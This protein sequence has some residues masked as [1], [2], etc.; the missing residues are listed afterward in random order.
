M[1][2]FISISEALKLVSPFKG[3]KKEVLAFISN[4][5]TAFEV[6]DPDNADVLYKFVL[7]RISGEPR[8]AIT[9]RNLENWEDT[10]TEKRTLD[11]HATQ[12]FGAKQE[13]C[14]SVSEWIQ[15]IQKLSSKFREAAL[16]D[17]EDDERVGIV[18]LGDKL[19][20]IC[21][22]QGL[23]SDRIQTIVRSRNGRTFDEIAETALEEESA[24]FSRN[25]RH[26][27]G[28]GP[29]KLVCH[30]CGKS[31]HI[32]AKC[33]L[34]DKKDVR[35]NK[36]GA[37]VKG[38]AG[39][40][41]GG[42]KRDIKCYNC[43]ETGHLSRECRKPRNPRRFLQANNAGADD[44]PPDKNAPSIGTLNMVRGGHRTSTE[45]VRLR[46]DASN[47]REL[48]LLVDTGADVSLL[49]PTN[50]DKSKLFDPDGR[51]KVKSVDGTII[52]TF[53]TVRTSVIVDFLKIPF[54]FQL[55]SKQV[56]IPCDGILG[57][58]FLEYAGAQICYTRG[59]LTFGAGRSKVSKALLP[60]STG[61]QT[62]KVSRLALPSRAELMVRLP[63]KEG[64]RIRE[65]ITE[66]REIQEGVYLAGAVTTVQAGYAITSIV[67]TNSEGVEIDEPVLE[68]EEIETGK[69]EY[70]LEGEVGGKRLNRT[71]EVL[72]RLRLEHLNKE[73]R[74]QVEKMC[75]A[76]QDI[77]HLPGEILTSTTTVQH[78]IRTEPGVEPV[79]V[80]P[81]RL[82]ETQ[83]QEVRKQVEE[84]RRGGIIT[85]SR[86]PWNSPLLIVPKK[87]DATGERKWRL[88][89]DYRQV[90][91]KTVGDAYP[92]PDVTEILDQLGQSK[93][94]SCIDMAMGYHQIKVA[95]HDR[96]KTAFST[97]EGH[98]EYTRLPFGLKTAPATFQRM[99]N[100]V[101][102]GLTG[103]RCFVFLDDIVVYARSLAE[104]DIKLREVFD[105]IREN[106]LKL[107][108][109]KCEFLRK[110]VSYLGH[111]ISEN[112]VSPEPAKT[113]AIEEYPPPQNV[114]QLRSF[115]GL[116]SYYRRFVPN[117]SHIAAP[118]HRLLKK[119]AVY[120]WT[121]ENEQAFQILK[122][123]L[124]SAPILKYPDFAQP[125][126]LTTDASEE[127]LGAVLSQGE[128]SRDLPVAFAS[129]TLS[130]AE[131][132]YSTTEKELLAVVWGM[133]YFR[134]YLYGKTFKVV[135][136]HKPLTWIMNVKDPGSRLLRWRIKLEEYDYEVVYR[137]G[138]LN[139]NA[140]A[141]SRIS[142]L[143]AEMGAPGEKREYVFDDEVKATILYEYHDS[144]LGGHRGMN[145][146]FREV[147][148]RYEWP[149]MKRD[150]EGYVKRCVSCQLNKNLSPRRKA[151]MEITTTARQ[152][153]ERCALDIVGPTDVTNK[154]NR[155]ILTFQDDLTKF[156]V[157]TPIPTQDAETVAREFVQNVVLRYGIPEVVLTDQGANF[158][159]ELFT[160]V[161]KLLQIKKV[162]TTAFHPESNGGLERSHRVL[163]EYLRHYI[164]EDQRDWDEWVTYATHCYNVTTHRTTGYSPFELLFGHQARIPS[165]LQAQ[166][167]PRYN[168]DDYVSELRGRLQSAHAIARENLLQGKVRSKAHFDKKTVQIALRV[169]DKV[170]LF[171]E[172]V[173]RGR[174]R[175]LGAQWVGPYFVTAVEGVNATIKRG[176]NLVKVHVNRLKPFY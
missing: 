124:M 118:L 105:R 56:D 28:T 101:L 113:R 43:G 154:G 120:E 128:I 48:L 18:A 29:G 123:K 161:C 175:K 71:E 12:L 97:K 170:L 95:E 112:G 146:T 164:A 136:D 54:T 166:P 93:Y 59:T 13:K 6:I 42:R 66:K 148:K 119:D 64:T 34:K 129:R 63:V 108:P 44:R 131:R 169:G 25:E 51:V 92:L 125:F 7:T 94:F 61:S 8:V 172:S 99:M 14:E 9:H 3:E 22:V 167:T 17:C 107:K 55:V 142:T 76:Y 109:E 82:P 145:K 138:A 75:A 65:G 98:W 143:A 134:P 141:L 122:G 39:K 26:R 157:A 149:N 165:V 20:N 160:N 58:D 144:P 52:E 83:K 80:K 19:R 85:E 130:K 90:N 38:I 70:P 132:S 79:N 49:K 53:G 96:A 84:L 100:V 21:F 2:D 67:N 106:N 89:I 35:V 16:Q 116:M 11:F 176:R 102:S 5:D 133:R 57:R 31:G 32:A 150:I 87:V 73:E 135:T 81:Y 111:V 74:Q 158:L 40:T 152:P 163:V 15:N 110:E 117:F 60:I 91:Q 121:V 62:K 159:S 155:Y 126:I 46:T 10:Y 30:N 147:S 37:E 162:Q 86:S 1:A 47:G 68:M 156:M 103:S 24:I 104:H 171:D 173:R 153:F 27:Q 137:K 77:F 139:T 41:W 151:P 168:Y 50:L 4:V 45:C 36:L 114:K 174:S 69:G 72:K 88:V 78:E 115:L 33:F 127:G 23:F 140:D